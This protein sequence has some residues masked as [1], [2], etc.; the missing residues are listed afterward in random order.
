M[1][2]DKKTSEKV[3]NIGLIIGMTFFSFGIIGI[4]ILVYKSTDMGEKLKPW[5]RRLRRSRD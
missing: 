1:D 2:V 5:T 3:G 4:S